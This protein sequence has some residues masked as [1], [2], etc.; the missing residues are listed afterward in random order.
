MS[1]EFTPTKA[2]LLKSK[3]ALDFSKKGF[4]LLD[5]KKNRT[6]SRSNGAS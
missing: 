4:S 2:N 5:K 1:Q 6:D 3:D